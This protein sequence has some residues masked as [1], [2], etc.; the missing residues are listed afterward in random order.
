MKLFFFFFFFLLN[1]LYVGFLSKPLKKQHFACVKHK[2]RHYHLWSADRKL[3]A[4]PPH[5]D[6]AKFVMKWGLQSLTAPSKASRL[7]G[8]LQSSWHSL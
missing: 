6:R 8:V 1:V 4:R 5:Q 7:Q 3:S 2:T